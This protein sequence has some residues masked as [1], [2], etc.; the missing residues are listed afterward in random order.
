M[1]PIVL[2]IHHGFNFRD[3]GGYKTKAGQTVR[4]HRL[5]RSGRLNELS[6]T[7]LTYLTDYGLQAIVDFRS[8]QE[9]ADAPDQVPAGAQD[10]FD[11]V[12]P[13]D[14]TKVTEEAEE[15]RHTEL[16]KDP[17]AG[18][19]SMVNTY[20]SIVVQPSAKKAYR[21]FFDVLLSQGSDGAVLFHCS[22]G[23]D[24]T[25]MGAVYLLTAL[26]VDPITIRQDYL[27]SNLYLVAEGQRMV[28]EVIQAGGSPALQSSYRSLGG[29]ANEYLDSALNTI[30]REYG[31]LPNY[32]KNELTLSD[33]ERRDL[34]ALYLK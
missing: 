23:K 28:D 11:P 24:R 5:L 19:R 18:F 7:D 4:T 22:A 32:L 12:F 13:T 6:A 10:L 8:P 31:N 25:G 14:E 3:L 1:T 17:L 34:R 16:A 9:R 27:A 30:N 33:A 20:A 2:P 15:A 29:V 21:Q 26:G